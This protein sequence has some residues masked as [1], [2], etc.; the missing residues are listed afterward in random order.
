MLSCDL[1]CNLSGR[2]GGFIGLAWLVRRFDCLG[3]SSPS[4]GGRMPRRPLSGSENVILLDYLG[5]AVSVFP[6]DDLFV[7]RMA[8]VNFMLKLTS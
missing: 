7:R 8:N 6:P 2:L 4:E 5:Y 3:R 1:S